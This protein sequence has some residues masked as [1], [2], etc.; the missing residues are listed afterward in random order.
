MI[1]TTDQET[2]KFSM[3]KEKPKELAKS[4]EDCEAAKDFALEVK[5]VIQSCNK[6][7]YY[8]A[9]EMLE[10]PQNFN[11]PVKFFH[12]KLLIVVG[13]FA[14][15][16][17][18]IVKTSQGEECKEDLKT[19]FKIFK[20]AKL[21]PRNLFGLRDNPAKKDLK[22]ADVLV[23][24]GIGVSKRPKAESDG[25]DPR[26]EFKKVKPLVF[27][28]FCNDTISK[29]NTIPYISGCMIIVGYANQFKVT[30]N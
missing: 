2:P 28:I 22:F 30:A 23:A 26:E 7:E 12:S 4:E 19:A 6:T 20:S 5:I 9:L 14:G 18:A 11:K 13:T 17:A 21:L 29:W 25:I 10:P 24:S 3:D 27:N 16:E 15:L 1:I 8:A